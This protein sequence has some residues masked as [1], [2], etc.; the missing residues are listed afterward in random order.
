MIL[1]YEEAKELM[2]EENKLQYLSDMLELFSKSELT[3]S[4]YMYLSFLYLNRYDL[5]LQYHY[6]FFKKKR[7]FPFNK[8]E[9]NQLYDKELI[10]EQWISGDPDGPVITAKGRKLMDELLKVNPRSITIITEKKERM[11]K[12]LID[13]YPDYFYAN[14]QYY[15]TKGFRK[16]KTHSG[17]YIE[18]KYDL[19][20]YYYEIIEGNEEL[21]KSILEKIRYAKRQ[22]GL[23]NKGTNVPQIRQTI[24]NFVINKDWEYIKPIENSTNIKIG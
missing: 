7:E 18:G 3:S 13:E 10:S 1:S 16:T 22:N 14:H 11:G 15:P 6:E 12:E 19:I 21:H 4:Q 24:M 2:L 17:K 9:I 8:K 5:L 23:D 20:N